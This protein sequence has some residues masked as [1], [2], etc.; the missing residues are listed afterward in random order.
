MES[1]YEK[2]CLVNDAV[3]I[4]K[5]DKAD[6]EYFKE[7]QRALDEGKDFPTEWTATGTQFQIPYVFKNCFSKEPIEFSDLCET[8]EV[9]TVLY[10]DMNEGLNDGQQAIY[11]RLKEVRAKA[12]AGEKLTG[13]ESKLLYN[14]VFADMTDNELAEKL[15]SYHSYKFIG[16]VG[17]FC[18]IKPGCG[19]GELVREQ[20][21]KNGVTGYDA[22]V[23]TKGYRWLEAED[24][25]KNNKQ[26]DIDLSY[27]DNL[28]N[29][30]IDTISNFGD[31]EWFVSSD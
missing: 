6:P 15:A 22:V 11:E 9:K 30:A 27:Y 7:A 26:N 20:L 3:Y 2:M 4:A 28:V 29:T 17:L 24:V 16:R 31:Y 25:A 13:P 19:G 1:I 5:K 21:K 23:G 18:P 14:E 12:L 10:L 8:K